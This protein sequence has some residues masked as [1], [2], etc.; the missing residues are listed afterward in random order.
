M[1]P[2]LTDRVIVITGASS[3]IGAAT[4]L[5]CARAGLHVVL[6]GRDAARLASV[7]DGVRSAGRTAVT[8]AGDVAAP[9][10]SARLLDAAEAALG[11]FDIVFAN[12]G[13]GFRRAMHETSDEELRRIFDVNF[14]AAVDLLRQAARRLIAA[15]R[16][17]HLLMCSSALAHFPLIRFSA[18]SATKAAQHHVC[19]AMAL[20]LRP[21]RIAVS[22]VHPVTTRTAFFARAAAESGRPFDPAHAYDHVPAVLVQD[23]ARVAD[24]VLRC[25]RRPRPEVWT[26]WLPRLAAAAVALAPRLM[27]LV[28]VRG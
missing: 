13:Y 14:F 3:G 20:E 8:V 12:A 24:A 27:D 2:T 16:P 1:S 9:G 22:S 10:E 28:A 21:H 23:A 25:L 6:H 18:Y 5:A 7:A 4:A 15:A 19:R 17:G 26:S 11:R